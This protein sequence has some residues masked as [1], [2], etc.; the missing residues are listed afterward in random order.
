MKTPPSPPPRDT[1]TGVALRDVSG[2]VTSAVTWIYLSSLAGAL[3]IIAGVSL[4]AGLGWTLIVSGAFLFYLAAV[5]I[6]GLN[7]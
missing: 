2:I 7:G 6:R 4:L 1:D 5:L 3:C